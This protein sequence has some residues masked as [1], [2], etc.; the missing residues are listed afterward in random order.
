[1]LRDCEFGV[2]SGLCRCF[3]GE[4]F[5]W[6]CVVYG[7][8]GGIDYFVCCWYLGGWFCSCSCFWF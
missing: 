7:L 3:G 8:V 1:M 5:C 2:M 4:S 6:R